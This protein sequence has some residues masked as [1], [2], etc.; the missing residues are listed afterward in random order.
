MID[1]GQIGIVSTHIGKRGAIIIPAAFRH[2]LGLEEGTPVTA[3]QYDGGVLIRPAEADD[4]SE[5]ERATLIAGAVKAYAALRNDPVAWAEDQEEQAAWEHLGIETWPRDTRLA[6][7]T[8]TH[9]Q[10]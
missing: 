5:E 7:E 2:Q 3:E 6:D 10:Q 1:N 9:D 4:F 8:G